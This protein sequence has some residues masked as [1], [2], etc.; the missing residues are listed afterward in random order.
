MESNRRTEIAKCIFNRAKKKKQTNQSCLQRNNAIMETKVV[1]CYLFSTALITQT[2]NMTMKKKSEVP[3]YTE[4]CVT[5]HSW[6]EN[7]D[8]QR[9]HEIQ[10]KN[11]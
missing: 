1:K 10:G 5:F 2:I 8:K 3:R 6:S 9:P 4:E 7:K 11:N